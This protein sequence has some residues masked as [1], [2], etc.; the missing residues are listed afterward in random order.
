VLVGRGLLDPNDPVSQHVPELD[1][2]GYTGATVR[3][4]L[5]MR[6]GIAFREAYGDPDAELAELERWISA[7]PDPGEPTRG[8]YAYLTTLLADRP[9]GQTFEYR[10]C[11]TDALGW[12][13]ERAT[14]T[15]MADLIATTLWQPMGAQDD[16]ELLIDQR[17]TAVHDG[18]LCATARDIA[19]FG[20][21]L[22][23]G[24][25]VAG[26]DV[27]PAG[28]LAR[29]W[30]VDADSRAAFA[31]SPSEQQ[32]PGGWYRDQL[33]VRPG[34]YGDVMLCIGIHG[35]LVHVNQRTRTVCV[36]L[37]TWPTPQN[38]KALTDTIRA[39]DEVGAQLAGKPTRPHGPAGVVTGRGA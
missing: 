2:S 33:W 24:G 32:F 10:S 26:T 4:L 34:P 16:A 36:K 3:D 5:D 17:G 38:P 30:T 9:H 25:R 35:Q 13:L 19:K 22:L 15:R 20:L 7:P 18:G 21:L 28:W 14:G 27:V 11:E 12:V 1:V 29:A 37:S 39:F 8:L 23:D 6:S 31:A